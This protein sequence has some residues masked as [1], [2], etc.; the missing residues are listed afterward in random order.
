MMT[1]EKYTAGTEVTLHCSFD[2]MGAPLIA[3]TDDINNDGTRNIYGLHFEVV[4]YNEGCNV[5]RIK[6]SAEAVEWP[7][8]PTLIEEPKFEIPDGSPVEITVRFGEKQIDACVNGHWVNAVI[9]DL[10]ESFHVGFTACEG[11]NHFYDFSITP[12]QK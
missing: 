10:P 1:K 2:E 8:D 6:P 5:W 3:F 4:A 7:I 9:E 11:I 12:A